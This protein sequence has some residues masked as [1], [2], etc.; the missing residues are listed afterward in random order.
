MRVLVTGHRG[1]LGTVLTPMMIA[2]G[3]EV[4]GLDS[5]LFERCGFGEP[6]IDVPQI[7]KDVRDARA[8]D[9]EGF[10]AVLHLA[11]LSNDPL[12]DF[13]PKLTYEINHLASVSLARLAKEAGVGRFVFSSSCSVYGKTEEEVINEDARHRPLT[14]YSWS[15]A[16]AERDI[17]KLANANF[18]PT[19]LRSGTAYGMSP[20]LRFDLVLNNLTAWAVATGRIHIK[21]DGTAWRPIVHI[22]DIARAFITA[23]RAP[24]DL[25]HNQAFNVGRTDQNYRVR[26]LA[27][28]VEETVPGCRVEYAEDAGPDNR[29]YR[30]DCG[31]I[32]RA[33]PEFKPRWDAR[34][35]AKQLC[36][37]Y[38][39]AGLVVEDFEG[40]RYNRIKHIKWLIGEGHLDAGLRQ[41]ETE[42]AWTGAQV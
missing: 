34:L 33:L 9:M 4:V 41:K 5:G 42:P 15:K 16:L 23:I 1:Y 14:A 25:V 31:K 36:E 12:G 8:S 30:V 27:A 24:L 3:I 19:F 20:R 11:G 38:L 13:S 22:E 18:N 35:G 2:E 7:K 28:I 6:T 39:K 17:V 21:S 29:S 40:V 10:D 26:E 32:A 37:A